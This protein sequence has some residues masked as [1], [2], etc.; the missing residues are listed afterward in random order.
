MFTPKQL[1]NGE[2]LLAEYYEWD[3]ENKEYKAPVK[4]RYK[5]YDDAQMREYMT[6]RMQGTAT[7]KTSVSIQTSANLNFKTIHDKIYLYNDDRKYT[8]TGIENVKNHPN[9]LMHTFMP[10][11][12]GI[13]PIRIHLNKEE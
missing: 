6:Q 3:R 8:I 11:A 2:F 4:F 12:K 5:T 9:S 10:R 1:A 13:T 7:P